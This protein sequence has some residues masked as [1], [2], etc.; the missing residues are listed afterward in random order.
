MVCIFNSWFVRIPL[1]LFPPSPCLR[2]AH[3]L[4]LMQL[5]ALLLC[6][7][8]FCSADKLLL[9]MPRA[10]D[11]DKGWDTTDS[12]CSPVNREVTHGDSTVCGSPLAALGLIT[13]SRRTQPSTYAWNAVHSLLPEVWNCCK[14]PNTVQGLGHE[15][16]RSD[17]CN[18]EVANERQGERCLHSALLHWGQHKKGC[19]ENVD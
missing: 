4:L 3:V 19:Q 16:R 9:T 7:C 1:L 17:P 5:A 11:G 15:G 2:G 8:T 18:M 12:S 14:V 13:H 10:Q 6:T